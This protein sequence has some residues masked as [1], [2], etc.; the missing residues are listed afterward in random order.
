ML[1]RRDLLQRTATGFGLI[2]LASILDAEQSPVRAANPQA[3]PAARNPLAPRPP[4]VTGRAKRIIHVFM[5]GGPSQ[6]DTFD[7]KPELVR[8]NGRAPGGTLASVRG[9]TRTLMA[10]PFRFRNC[11]QSGLPVSEIFPRI[12]ECVDDLCII[13]SMHTNVP[14][15]EPSLLM[16]TCGNVQP[17]RPSMGSWLVYGLGT[18]NQNLPG[19]I[20]MCPGF[21]VVG[22]ALWSN[23]FL[24]G[25]FQGAHINNSNMDP[26]RVLQ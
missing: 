23:S 18:E 5:N 16:M 3:A 12:A 6:V 15:H 8:Y 19:F 10:S 21:P 24:P 9:G 25:I 17:V 14:N 2:G 1:T 11:G 4:H 13:R 26:R 22:P 20:T 7:P